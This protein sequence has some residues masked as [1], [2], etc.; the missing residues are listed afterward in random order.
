MYDLAFLSV[1]L[2][3]DKTYNMDVLIV[4]RLS[5]NHQKGVFA[6]ASLLPGW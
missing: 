2:K 1:A 3:N 4:C 6:V 5:T